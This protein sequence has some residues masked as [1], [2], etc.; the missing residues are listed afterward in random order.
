M[1]VTCHRRATVVYGSMPNLTTLRS[2][3]LGLATCQACQGSPLTLHSV[4][5][6]HGGG[7]RCAQRLGGTYLTSNQ[8]QR[9]QPVA[10]VL[11]RSLLLVLLAVR[12]SGRYRVPT[13]WCLPASKSACCS[14]CPRPLRQQ[15]PHRRMVAVICGVAHHKRRRAPP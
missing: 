8:A 12:P 13:L 5:V 4:P 10:A 15:G 1:T 3:W 7:H 11:V 2:L 9:P 14:L 6:A